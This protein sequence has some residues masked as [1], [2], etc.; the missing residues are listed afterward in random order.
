MNTL[1]SENK[2]LG[3]ITSPS[4]AAKVIVFVLVAAGLIAWATPPVALIAGMIF[5]LCL[6]NP[7]YHRGHKIA[8]SLLQICVVMLGFGMNLPVILRAGWNGSLFAALT[9][10]TTLSFVHRGS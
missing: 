9:I 8:K 10:G 3:W 1:H 2:S 4:H 5:T 7:F 6:G